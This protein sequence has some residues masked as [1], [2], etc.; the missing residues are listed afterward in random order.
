MLTGEYP[1]IHGVRTSL[2][3][4]G[5]CSELKIDEVPT[6]GHYLSKAGYDVVYK[7]EWGLSEVQA[8]LEHPILDLLGVERNADEDL[9]PF[10]FQGWEAHM[11]EDWYARSIQITNEAVE[12]IRRRECVMSSESLRGSEPPPWA[13]V[14]SY[15]DIVPDWNEMKNEMREQLVDLSH[16]VWSDA[17]MNTSF[18]CGNLRQMELQRRNLKPADF[19]KGKVVHVKVTEVDE[20]RRRLNLVPANTEVD[21]EVDILVRDGVRCEN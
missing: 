2:D 1:P 4:T 18:S 21:E 9:Q 12:Y 5:N 8:M 14:V 7:G 16:P 15:P 10:G 13:L 20:R 19:V 11:E 17:Q 6:L 3:K